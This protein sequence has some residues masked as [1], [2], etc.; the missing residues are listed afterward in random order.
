MERRKKMC[1]TPWSVVSWLQYKLIAFTIYS[2]DTA[3]DIVVLLVGRSVRKAE[4]GGI[5][6]PTFCSVRV[7]LVRCVSSCCAT[8]T[9]RMCNNVIISMTI[10]L[11]I[12]MQ[13]IEQHCNI[14]KRMIYTKTL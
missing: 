1:M 8:T 12:I 13:F 4:V 7:A 9:Q 6:P 5:S 11:D 2:V 10:K 3:S 14:I